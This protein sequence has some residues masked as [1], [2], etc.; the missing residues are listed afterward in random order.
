MIDQ[1]VVEKL[2]KSMQQLGLIYRVI[3]CEEDGDILIGR[4]RYEAGARGSEHVYRIRVAPYAEKWGVSLEAAKEIFKIHG[5]VQRVVP[6]EETKEHLLRLARELE[7]QGVP[8]EK[9]SARIAELVPLS[10]GY[11]YKLLPEEYKERGRVEAIKAGIRRESLLGDI[12]KEYEKETPEEIAEELCGET[13]EEIAYQAAEEAAP[14]KRASKVQ[15]GRGRSEF[16]KKAYTDAEVRLAEELSRMQVPFK[17]QVPVFRER[18]EEG[19]PKAYIVDF[20]VGNKLVV[21]VDGEA[22]DFKKDEERD[23]EL[24][25]LGYQVKHFPNELVERYPG[26]VAEFIRLIM[27]EVHRITIEDGRIYHNGAELEPNEMGEYSFET[28]GPAKIYVEAV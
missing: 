5:N 1:E 4:H 27:P 3:V 18:A 19:K 12:R 22:H 6:S 20:L 14:P 2:K 16:V 24:R 10:K 28:D 17:T 23:A 7:K 25:K 26:F 21:E 8:K 11:I 15:A 13:V 9:V